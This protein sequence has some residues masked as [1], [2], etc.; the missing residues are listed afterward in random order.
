MKILTIKQNEEVIT[1]KLLKEEVDADSNVT[2]LF[3]DETTELSLD[4][5]QEIKIDLTD[6]LNIHDNVALCE[7]YYNRRVINEE[8]G[9]T[10]IVLRKL[11]LLKSDELDPPRLKVLKRDDL[12]IVPN[13][14]KNL[15]FIVKISQTA[16]FHGSQ[17]LEK[18]SKIGNST[19]LQF[20]LT[21]QVTQIVDAKLVLLARENLSEIIIE[22]NDYK[23]ISKIRQ[24]FKYRFQA[25]VD[26]EKYN[27]EDDIYDAY[28][29]V[30]YD[31]AKQFPE[32]TKRIRL[33]NT[34][35][36]RRINIKNLYLEQND[37]VLAIHPYFTDKYNNISFTV[38]NIA[39]DVFN[40]Y[41]YENIK[42]TDVILIGERPYKAQDTGFALFKQ[43]RTKYPEL[44]VY[45]VIQYDSPEYENVKPYGNTVDFGSAEHTRLLLQAKTLFCS[46][47]FYYL[48]PFRHKRFEKQ[49]KARKVFIQHGV[50]G[51]KNMSSLYGLNGLGADQFVVSSQFEKE[52]VE[53]NFNYEPNQIAITGLSR[54]DTLFDGKNKVKNQILIIPTWRDW[55]SSKNKF[56]S[57]DYYQYYNDLINDEQLNAK[58]T[59]NNLK[60][61]FCLH[62]NMQK[63]T[64][65]F[66]SKF[67]N[68]KLVSQG[69]ID[70]QVLIKESKLMI[71]DY[72]SVAFD[73]SF[74]KKP[75]LYFQFDRAQ[76]LGEFG[77]FIDL[78]KYLPGEIVF[79]YDELINKA[80]NVID[81]NFVVS[82]D[83]QR[84]SKLFLE[85]HDQNNSERILA[86]SNEK[87]KINKIKRWYKQSEFIKYLFATISRK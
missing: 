50:L 51:V 52:I 34:R 18:I 64:Q 39:L 26:W 54:F 66:E 9:E 67:D 1:L 12:Y 74:L 31:C 77:S 41:R 20:T 25:N 7:F 23:N 6:Y 57:S 36:L 76:Y 65:Y 47:N 55:L 71:T 28:V 4:D 22:I 58:L 37:T 75:V 38:H 16:T 10:E 82:D 78:D 5:N 70:V 32:L 3:E 68:V 83:I 79:T 15:V 35:Y 69:E 81:T 13:F 46:H 87:L 42:Q 14:T 56:L 80:C 30:T 45:Y 85:Y 59:E 62:P 60:L 48:Y 84:R 73:F 19:R 44:P 21:T 86:I 29:Q 33:G 2:I 49:I 8:T 61:V 11:K 40:V 43:L 24:K 27:F 17:Y 53:R 72:S 63:F